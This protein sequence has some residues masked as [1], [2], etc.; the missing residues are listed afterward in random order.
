MITLLEVFPGLSQ[1]MPA[2][3]P[4]LTV[5]GAFN[6]ALPSQQEQR[7]ASV[8]SERE[9]R[10]MERLKKSK[11]RSMK[12]QQKVGMNGQATTKPARKARFHPENKGIQQVEPGQKLTSE[13]ALN[14][15]VNFFEQHPT[16]SYST[17]GRAVG[18]S[19][20]WVV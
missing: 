5:I 14:A 20:S 3:T 12:G 16:G 11:E 2:I 10:K 8:R 6:L 1:Y 15:L 9:A 4:F 13:E 17:A 7:E 19:K 18:R